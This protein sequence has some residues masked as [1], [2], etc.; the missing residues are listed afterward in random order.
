[1]SDIEE[2]FESGEDGSIE[3]SDDDKYGEYVCLN[4]Q[5]NSECWEELMKQI[6]NIKL[7]WK[8]DIIKIY[9]DLCKISDNKYNFI[10]QL[11]KIIEENKECNLICL[12]QIAYN[13]GQYKHGIFIHNEEQR[14]FYL[15][16]KL[17]NMNTYTFEK[18]LLS[19]PDDDN[20]IKI[21]S[22]RLYILKY[23]IENLEKD[24]DLLNLLVF[25]NTLC[26]ADELIFFR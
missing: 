19:K 1:M 24:D 3:A 11:K 15:K 4:Q 21:G 14:N 9:D 8:E 23:I 7:P 16:H 2:D 25:T 20:H 10:S 18:T 13:C 17:Y 5:N 22:F 12:M 6:P 26:K